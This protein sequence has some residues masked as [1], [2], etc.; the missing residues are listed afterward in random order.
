M[1]MLR[2]GLALLVLCFAVP[3]AAQDFASE[4]VVKDY[5]AAWNAHDA[6][7]AAAFLDENVIYYDASLG[8]PVMGRAEAEAQ[9]IQSFITAAPD[10]VWEMR[11]PA[12]STPGHVAF[13]WVFRGT[14]SGNWSDG[15]PG[16]GK[17]FEIYGVSFINLVNGK[18]GYQGDY[19]DALTFL[20]QLGYME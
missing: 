17:A 18:I 13:E 12:I 2:R 10:L 1:S 9:I 5:M 20:Q 15:S 14:N 8:E 7:A 11:G 16:S 4:K 6:A 19:Y 3:A